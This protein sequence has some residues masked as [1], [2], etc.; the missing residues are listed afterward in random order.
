MNKE[1]FLERSE[2]M[3]ELGFK[4][5]VLSDKQIIFRKSTFI[6]ERNVIIS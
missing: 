3:Y 1:Y 6:N 4:L 5:I 2:M